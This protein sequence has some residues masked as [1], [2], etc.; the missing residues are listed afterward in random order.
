MDKQIKVFPNIEE[1]NNFAAEKFVELA[2]RYID[3]TFQSFNVALAGGSTPKA[4]FRLLA[5]EK[6]RHKVNWN[7][8]YFFFGDERN[9]L[10]D[11]AD[12]NFRMANENLFQPL[13]ISE[14]NIKR[15]QT[16]YKNPPRIAA[17][18]KSS[19]T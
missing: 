5:S 2:D 17:K 1:L 6:F 4:L 11:H 16:E 13:Q 18:A 3:S 19:T 12:S 15:W 7:R 14:F 10:P 9:V 8:V